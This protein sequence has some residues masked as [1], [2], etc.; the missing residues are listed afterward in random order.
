MHPRWIN[1]GIRKALCNL[2]GVGSDQTAAPRGPPGQVAQAEVGGM[3][4]TFA[5]RHQ[6][7]ARY[8]AH[9]LFAGLVETC[10]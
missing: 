6:L 9:L 5:T 3:P 10:R 2:R 4:P 1:I 8:E 7:A